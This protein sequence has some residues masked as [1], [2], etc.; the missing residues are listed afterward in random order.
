MEIGLKEVALISHHNNVHV[1]IAIIAQKQPSCGPSLMPYYCAN[2][3]VAVNYCCRFLDSHDQCLC[4]YASRLEV[5]SL[6][7]IIVN[8]GSLFGGWYLIM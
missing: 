5:H 6:S 1:R 7:F 2:D 3:A 8:K 4:H